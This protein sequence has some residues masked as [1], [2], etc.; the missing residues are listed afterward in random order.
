MPI[1]ETISVGVT[2][3]GGVWAVI[4]MVLAGLGLTYGALKLRQWYRNTLGHKT[5]RPDNV[6]API[7]LYR[8]MLKFTLEFREVLAKNGG[9]DIL[10]DAD[11]INHVREQGARK[12]I[13]LLG[14]L[15]VYITYVKTEIEEVI[16]RNASYLK[17]GL[18]VGANKR[19]RLIGML[20]DP[21]E[22]LLNSI[23]LLR[24]E[25]DP[26]LIHDR[27]GNV[28]GRT[29]SRARLIVAVDVLGYIAN[30]MPFLW[31]DGM[32]SIFFNFLNSV[33][34]FFNCCYVYPPKGKTGFINNK[35]S[36]DLRDGIDNSY[37]YALKQVTAH[38]SDDE[39]TGVDVTELE[40]ADP[41]LAAWNAAKK[42]VKDKPS[43][44]KYFVN[45]STMMRNFLRMRPLHDDV[46]SM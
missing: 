19:S 21:I 17:W 16:E 46:E 44:V 14:E 34:L 10:F 27:L 8:D 42:L 33:S 28:R 25:T 24:N 15:K 7:K 3:L 1:L 20:V 38:Y 35:A 2:A 43:S 23:I 18:V 30:S 9:K 45:V 26:A 13:D 37:T 29:D 39:E 36:R 31:T 32:S 41:R 12:I 22:A 5:G 40:K 4:K 11:L 6:R